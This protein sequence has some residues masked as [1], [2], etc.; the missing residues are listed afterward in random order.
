MRA[1]HLAKQKMVNICSAYRSASLFHILKFMK[2]DKEEEWARLVSIENI[3][4]ATR[5]IRRLALGFSL[6]FIVKFIQQ[7]NNNVL[8]Q[9]EGLAPDRLYVG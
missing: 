8:V 2:D 4:N 7:R 5:T 6:A 9:V 3:R 1:L